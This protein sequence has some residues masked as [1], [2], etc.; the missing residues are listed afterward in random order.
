MIGAGTLINPIIKIVTTVAILAAVYFF[1][2]KPAL[3][4]TESISNDINHTVNHGFN[5]TNKE[6]NHAFSGIK[7]SDQKQVDQAI[8]GSNVKVTG[9]DIPKSAQAQLK[10]ANCIQQAAPNTAKIQACLK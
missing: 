9:S 8:K 3:D 7:S 1:A 10:V 4:T 6:L 2:I 5:Q